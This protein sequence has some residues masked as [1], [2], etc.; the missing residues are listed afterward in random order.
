MSTTDSLPLPR[1]PRR[2]CLAVPASEERMVR[3]AATA[4]DA[5]EVFLDLED[6]VA[7]SQ[8]ADARERAVWALRELDW[9]NRRVAVRVNAIGGGA[10]LDDLRAVVSAGDRLDTVI[11]PKVN[12]PADLHFV[13]RVLAELETTLR[14]DRRVGVEVLIETACALTEVERIAAASDRLEA[15]IFGPGDFA[16]SLGIPQLSVGAGDS[17]GYVLARVVTAAKAYGLQAIDGPFGAIADANGFRASARRS[18]RLGFDGKWAIHPGQIPL[19]HEVYTPTAEQLANARRLLE[20]YERASVGEG[21]GAAT[22]DGEMI[23]E[24]SR[25]IA[26]AVVARG[27]AAGL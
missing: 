13:D 26:E 9:A 8:K 11:V 6:A 10:C 22:L 14:R 2:S 18:A 21:R 27:A 24:A 16:A 20:E 1:R 5:D 7:P 4:L 15:L 25:R 3:K 17:W 23:D 19:C 12:G